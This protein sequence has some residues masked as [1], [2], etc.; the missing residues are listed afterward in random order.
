MKVGKAKLQAIRDMPAPT[1]VADVRHLCGTVQYM[2]RFLPDLAE[3]IEPIPALTRKNTPFVWS[4]ECENA[5]DTLKRNLSGS[6]CLAYCD[7]S[8]EV[9]IQ[10]DSSKHG[11]GALFLQE[12]RP[13]EYASRALKPSERNKI[14]RERS[15]ICF[16]WYREI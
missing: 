12:S 2:S 15:T 14:N 13:I 6:P 9:V 4:M 5:F 11:I 16:V 1:D 7:V 3:M 8:K 10:V